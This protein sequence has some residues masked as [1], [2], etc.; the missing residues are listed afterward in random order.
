MTNSEDIWLSNEE[1]EL[2]QQSALYATDK[3]VYNKDGLEDPIVITIKDYRDEIRE[4]KTNKEA[5][6]D[7]VIE[8]KKELKAANIKRELKKALYNYGRIEFYKKAGDGIASSRKKTFEAEVKS[9]QKILSKSALANKIAEKKD[10]GIRIELLVLFLIFTGIYP[11][12]KHNNQKAL[13]TINEKIQNNE[14]EKVS[15]E[16]FASQL[17]GDVD[18]TKFVFNK[19]RYSKGE[20]LFQNYKELE[21]DQ[22]LFDC[23]LELLKEVHDAELI[24]DLMKRIASQGAEYSEKYPVLK[25]SVYKEELRI[26][27]NK[28]QDQKNIE[29]LN[30]MVKNWTSEQDDTARQ[31]LLELFDLKIDKK[32][33][34]EILGDRDKIDKMDILLSS[35]TKLNEEQISV[36]LDRLKK[37]EKIELT[38]KLTA[39]D[40]L[41][42]YYKKESERQK[43][44]LWS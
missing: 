41:E 30:G 10:D 12:I 43:Q 33:R 40:L 29:Q 39:L 20:F 21:A 7:R 23:L 38:D 24:E 14:V 28:P 26:K 1:M 11:I 19:E 5:N 15:I 22:E 36:Q 27:D 35:F 18:R 32:L 17:M 42:S 4:L 8:K 44:E 2:L 13:E 37:K 31:I 34:D 6:N 9:I 25:Y 3:R 16:K